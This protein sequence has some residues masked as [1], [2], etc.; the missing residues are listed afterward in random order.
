MTDT[1][2]AALAEFQKALPRVIKDKTVDSVSRTTGKRT[3]YSY[4]GLPDVSEVVL[5]KMAEF[6]LS[7]C[8]RPTLHPE[9]G[10]VLAFQLLHTSGEE[11]SGFYPLNRDDSPQ[12]RGSA[13]TYARR[14]CLC[15][16]TGVAA[17]EDDDAQTAENA[18]ADG[19]PVNKDGRLSRSRTTDEQKEAAG[20]M[21]KAQDKEHG[22]LVKGAEGELEPEVAAKVEHGVTATPDDDPF[23]NIPR[24]EATETMDGLV[25]DDPVDPAL[26]RSLNIRLTSAGH[27]T[28][29]QRLAK[30]LAVTG[31][32]VGSTNDLG[33]TEVRQLLSVLDK[34]AKVNAP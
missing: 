14:Y 19:L 13:I 10:F 3:K 27:R 16:V 12:A 2:A 8:C 1:L 22:R 6:G 30:V 24:S 31:R 20:V 28:K 9:F 18:R 25:S 34:E 4:A 21:T 7:F 32:Q 5:P 11:R 33:D 26:V 23:Y 29:D 15:A 17:D